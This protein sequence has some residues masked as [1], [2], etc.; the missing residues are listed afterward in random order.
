MPKTKFFQI[1]DLTRKCMELTALMNY[2]APDD[3]DTF[4]D[5]AKEA[6]AQELLEL[7]YALRNT[8]TAI[9]EHLWC[10]DPAGRAKQKAAVEV[11]NTESALR[12]FLYDTHGII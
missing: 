7:D 10:L 2:F 5:A 6:T 4:R 11:I 12:E 1:R 3:Q 9:N 8:V